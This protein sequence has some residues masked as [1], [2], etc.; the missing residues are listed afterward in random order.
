MDF[1]D[2]GLGTLIKLHGS[3]FKEN[4]NDL[5]KRQPRMTVAG[6]DQS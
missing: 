3:D 5:S 2:N 4:C 6:T 1:S